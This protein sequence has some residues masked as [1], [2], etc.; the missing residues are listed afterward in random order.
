[1]YYNVFHFCK[2]LRHNRRQEN[3][4][5]GSIKLTDFSE[6][7]PNLNLPAGDFI[8]NRRFYLADKII[9]WDISNFVV[10]LSTS[11]SQI[12]QYQKNM[13]L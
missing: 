7:L 2:L 8:I 4:G 3:K 1:M 11:N 10:N 13:D 5:D 12:L 6:P 9:V